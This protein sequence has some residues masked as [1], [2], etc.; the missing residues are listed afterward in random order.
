MPSPRRPKAEQAPPNEPSTE[1]LVN[2][3]PKASPP[4]A[5]KLRA[6]SK[7]G[8]PRSRAATKPRTA[9]TE[10]GR[11]A[12]AEG[13][14]TEAEGRNGQARHR[15]EAEGRNGQARH[16]PK[17]KAASGQAR[18]RTEAEGRGPPDKARAEGGRQTG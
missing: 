15:T 6:A 4:V 9:V 3:K 1:E 8:S 12:E 17:P 18:H 14:R 16:A 7:S 11:P 2:A 10:A 5:S 13:R